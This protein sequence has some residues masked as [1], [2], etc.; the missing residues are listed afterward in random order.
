MESKIRLLSLNIC[1]KR[2]LTCLRAMIT[3]LRPDIIFLQEVNLS[4]EQLGSQISRDF[5]CK[6][7]NAEEDSKP[8]T[9]MIWKST[10]QVSDVS[11]VVAGRAQ[12]AHLDNYIL[13]N[14]YAPSGSSAK[15]ARN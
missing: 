8:G 1:L 14:V 7:N 9:A 11:N 10:L 15:H 3:D 6:V 5:K 13:L 12:L 4:D 2:N